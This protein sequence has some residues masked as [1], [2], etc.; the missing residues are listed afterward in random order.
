[1]RALLAAA[2]MSV[3]ACARGGA[4]T[5]DDEELGSGATSTAALPACTFANPL[6][7]GADPWVVKHDG[8]YLMVQSRRGAI[9]IYRS[10]KLTDVAR[11]M[12]GT[13]VWS[14]PGS[15]W[16]A[17]NLWAP[18]LHRIGD[19]WYVYYTAGRRGPDDAPF[20]HQRSGV[21]ESAGD[22][23]LG[24]YTD[25]GMLYTGDD[26][27]TGADPKWAIDLTVHRIRGQLYA[28]WSGWERNTTAARTPQHLYA[29]R[30][31]NPWTIA[32]S[33]V[34]IASPAEPWERKIDPKDG[35]DLQE[36]PEFLEKDGRLFVVYSTRES[37]LRGYQLGQLRLRAP[38]ADPLDPASWEKTG[39]VFSPTATVFAVGHN[40]FT[41]SPDGT[42]DWIV[43]HAKV[44]TTPGWR[45]VI[46]MQKFGWKADGSPDF[47]TPLPNGVAVPVPSGECAAD[48]TR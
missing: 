5:D 6:G 8:G 40:G 22:D 3:A 20:I 44:D 34:R 24:P 38:D 18:E 33:R 30:M 41:Q 25:R 23:P 16:N 12:N 10:T 39:P 11:G 27:A 42:E 1:M 13:R 46:R 17:T 37:W 28:M 47:G 29:A 7:P 26:V 31:A 2:L 43:Y 48:T 36:G 21:L 14:A 15:G 32:T 4:T 35:L 9:W 19:R 45:R